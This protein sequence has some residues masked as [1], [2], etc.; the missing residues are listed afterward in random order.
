MDLK[1][2]CQ[3]A[4]LFAPELARSVTSGAAGRRCPTSWVCLSIFRARPELSPSW[5]FSSGRIIPFENAFLCSLTIPNKCTILSICWCALK[6]AT[7]SAGF[8]GPSARC[9]LVKK[10][11]FTEILLNR[12]N[13]FTSM[14]LPNM[15]ICS[16]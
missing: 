9:S 1:P 16:M 4:K 5:R 12:S 7:T 10:N 13:S 2:F 15:K 11:R 14:F 6:S 8:P 3:P